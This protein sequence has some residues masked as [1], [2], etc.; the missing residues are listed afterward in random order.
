MI[1][2]RRHSLRF[3]IIQMMISSFTETVEWNKT[4]YSTSKY[5]CMS[6][7]WNWDSPTPS[8]ASECAPPPGTKRGGG[9]TRLR[10]RG[11]GS[12]NSDDW[13]KSLVLCLLCVLLPR[14]RYE[15]ASAASACPW[16]QTTA[17]TTSAAAST[18]TRTEGKEVLLAT[19]SR[20]TPTAQQ[21]ARTTTTCHQAPL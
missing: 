3:Q 7:R 12:P 9:H 1:F 5:E 15:E 13:R 14:V 18:T 10:V 16:S 21:T 19:A 20:T 8:L 6:P 4:F 11:W 2:A 17:G